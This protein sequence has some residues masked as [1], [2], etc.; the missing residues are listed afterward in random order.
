MGVLYNHGPEYRAFQESV[1]KAFGD[2]A[3]TCDAKLVAVE[4]WIFG[5][6]TPH[7]VVTIGGYSGHSP[8]LCVKLRPSDGE[9]GVFVKDGTDV[10]LAIIECFVKGESSRL[11]DEH[12][13]WK[14]ESIRQEVNQLA[15]KIQEV[16]MPFICS[17]GGDWA[18]VREMLARRY[19]KS[20]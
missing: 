10:G 15:E 16:A 6:R 2:L 18:G 13:V 3:S 19:D 5:F 4:P 12:R 9:S 14:A 11:F 8:S 7:A 20:H 1:S 17:P